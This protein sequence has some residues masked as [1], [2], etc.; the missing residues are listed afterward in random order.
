MAKVMTTTNNIGNVL[1][2]MFGVE[3]P[4]WIYAGAYSL[5]TFI[6]FYFF[7]GS[8]WFSTLYTI[9]FAALALWSYFSGNGFLRILGVII[10]HLFAFWLF[11]PV[12]FVAALISVMLVTIF[13]K[14]VFCNDG[15]CHEA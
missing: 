14:S 5:V 15:G 7:A 10:L 3:R 8:L 6:M 1:L 12:K 2:E 4:S 9:A 11:G 13:L